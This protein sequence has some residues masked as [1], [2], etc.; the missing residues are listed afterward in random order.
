[1]T[2]VPALQVTSLT[3]TAIKG[4]GVVRRDEVELT[5]TGVAGDRAFL[6]VDA[7]G[8]LLSMTRTGAWAEY[9]AHYAAESGILTVTCPD[10]TAVTGEVRLGDALE[11]DFFRHHKVPGRVVDGP[12]AE[13]FSDRVGQPV[14][15][16]HPDADNGGVDLRPVTLLGDASVDELARR[17]D[18]DA[19]DKRRFRMTIGFSGGAPHAE[20]GWEGRTVRVGG[21]ELRVEGPV[22]RCGA[23]NRDPVDGS[24]G[25]RALSLIKGYRG[26]GQSTLGRGVLFGVYADVVTP[27][28]I[29]VGDTLELAAA[30]AAL[31]H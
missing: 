21:A 9:S 18:L 29:A 5:R 4:L 16:V 14:R 25:V 30:P 12:W 27:G 1:M 26:L 28:R 17:S 22:K 15:L 8:N 10:G 2:P 23:V 13:L 24:G 3:T 19:V 20:D 31:S 6:M 7:E 11:V